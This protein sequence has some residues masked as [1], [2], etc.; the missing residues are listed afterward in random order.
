MIILAHKAFIFSVLVLAPCLSVAQQLDKVAAFIEATKHL[1]YLAPKG[2]RIKAVLDGRA[3]KGSFELNAKSCEISVGVS[4]EK[5]QMVDAFICAMLI[6]ALNTSGRDLVGQCKEKKLS[7]D[8]FEFERCGPSR[9]MVV[10]LDSAVP[11]VSVSPQ[12]FRDQHLRTSYS[13][14]GGKLLPRTIE[15]KNSRFEQRIEKIEYSGATPVKID[16]IYSAKKASISF[17]SCRKN[18]R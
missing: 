11:S 18:H 7:S 12:E 17:D 5:A 16:G 2:C 8:V 4:D 9:N 3:L 6:P 1:D 10:V 13:K 15:L 14:G